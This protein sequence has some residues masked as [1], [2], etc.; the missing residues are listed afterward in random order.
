VNL[1]VSPAKRSPKVGGTV[2]AGPASTP[3]ALL[4]AAC[5]PLGAEPP[6]AAN[7]MTQAENRPVIKADPTGSGGIA[8]GA[9]QH[10][11]E[12]GGSR[13]ATDG[14]RHKGLLPTSMVSVPLAI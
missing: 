1:A 4:S 9:A 7:K 14:R 6:A 3:N 12:R 11:P 2:I 10:K 13:S 5:A 8:Q